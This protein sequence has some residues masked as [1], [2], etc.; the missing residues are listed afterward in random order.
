[1]RHRHSSSLSSVEGEVRD[2]NGVRTIPAPLPTP[3]IVVASP[4]NPPVSLKRAYEPKLTQR[5]W[6]A[7]TSSDIEPITEHHSYD[8]KHKYSHEKDPRLEVYAGLPPSP[9]QWN[10]DELA[11][12]LETSLGSGNNAD[13]AKDN[14]SLV[15]ILDCVRTRG[16]TGRELL[17]LTDADLAGY[18]VL[19]SLHGLPH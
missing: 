14:P 19:W 18:V 16:L 10:T 9:K 1:V 12:Y 5:A 4:E 17:R 2:A 7:E 13:G 11:T 3:S 6:R 15:D 8:Q